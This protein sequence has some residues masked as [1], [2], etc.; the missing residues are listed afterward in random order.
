MNC[1]DTPLIFRPVSFSLPSSLPR[2]RESSW[3]PVF[4]GMTSGCAGMTE[5]SA[6]LPGRSAVLPCKGGAA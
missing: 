1:P 6:A 2:R 4:A 5:S 3:I